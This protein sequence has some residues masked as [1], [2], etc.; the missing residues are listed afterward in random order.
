MR[1]PTRGGLATTLHEIAQASGV[2]IRLAESA[3]PIRPEVRGACEMLGL[4]PLHVA[5][6]GKLVAVVPAE[7]AERALQAVR[8]RPL[9]ADAALIGDVLSDPAHL[10]TLRSVV[11]GER[12]VPPLTGAPLPRI[13]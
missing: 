7:E 4:D 2:G 6:E 1:D 11:G 9:G 12:V 5:N 3:I 8:T 13:C 10:V